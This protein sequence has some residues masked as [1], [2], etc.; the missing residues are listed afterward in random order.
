MTRQ[1][2]KKLANAPFSPSFRLILTTTKRRWQVYNPVD[3]NRLRAL[4]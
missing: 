4:N 3:A 1:V 2:L